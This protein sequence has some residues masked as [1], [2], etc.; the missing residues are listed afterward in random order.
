V[1]ALLEAFPWKGGTAALGAEAYPFNT[2]TTANAPLSIPVR[3][4][5]ALYKEQQLSLS[6]LLFEQI[7]KTESR[8]YGRATAGLLETEYAG[9]DLEAAWPLYRGRLIVDANG[10]VTR[11]RSPD[12]PFG[13]VGDTWYRTAFLGMRLNVPEADLWFDV[14]GGRF[15]AGD[16][17]ARFTVSKFVRGVTL[18]AWYSVTDTSIFSDPGEGFPDR[19]PVQ[20]LALDPRRRAGCRPSPDTARLHREKYGDY[21]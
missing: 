6:R 18:S 2:V 3:S 21:P 20:P 17:G 9:L 4:D 11:K 12:D 7:G 10:S 19:L 15:L 14:K 8:L 13:F 5:I 1:A 16:Y